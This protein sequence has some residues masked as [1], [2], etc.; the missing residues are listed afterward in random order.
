MTEDKEIREAVRVVSNEV[1]SPIFDTRYTVLKQCL[2]TLL[3]LAERYLQVGEMLPKKSCT[4]NDPSCEGYVRNKAI[5]DCWLA[6]TRLV[7]G[8]KTIDDITLCKNCNCM[9]KTVSTKCGKCGESK[10][11]LTNNNE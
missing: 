6:Y 4:C 8:N 3:A 2:Q 7:D 1:N 5:E 10:N 11:N 9:T